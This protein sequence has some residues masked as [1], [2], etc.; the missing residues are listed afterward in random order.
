MANR[1]KGEANKLKKCGATRLPSIVLTIADCL[2]TSWQGQAVAS[3]PARRQSRLTCIL[4][5]RLGGER[6]SK[7]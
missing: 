4:P 6:V 5:G 7:G 2:R 3:V 1:Y